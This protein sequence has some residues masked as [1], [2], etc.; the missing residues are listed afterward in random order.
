MFIRIF[1]F[2]LSVFVNFVILLSVVRGKFK[3]FLLDG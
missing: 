1:D 2:E 3:D